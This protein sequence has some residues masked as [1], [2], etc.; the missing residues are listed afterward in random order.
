MHWN[1]NAKL[2]GPRVKDTSYWNN[3]GNVHVTWHWRVFVQP[4]SQ[5]KGNKYYNTCVCICSLWYPPC[6][7]HV[8]YCLLWPALFY[9]ISLYNLI[10]GTIKKKVIEH[11]M[12]FK[13]L[14][15]FCL[16]HFSLYDE[17]S[18]I[19]SKTYTGLQ[20]KYQL[21]LSD[22]NKPT[23]FLTDIWEILKY[24]ILWK[25]DQWKLSCSMRTDG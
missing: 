21:L 6:N 25:S 12:G 23:I 20:V 10:N 9:N 11:K 24:K 17:M 18:E 19:W 8:P 15:N 14:Y 4:L 1:L 2:L 5:W 3:R 22:F 16:K 7:A 13:F